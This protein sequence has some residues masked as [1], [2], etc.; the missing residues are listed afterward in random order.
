LAS[1]ALV[2][3]A[4]NI[5]MEELVMDKREEAEEDDREVGWVNPCN[6]MSQNERVE[7]DLAVHPMRLVLVKVSL[8]S[9]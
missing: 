8:S 9:D 7:L 1:Q 2:D 6:E 5:E 4:G 3:L